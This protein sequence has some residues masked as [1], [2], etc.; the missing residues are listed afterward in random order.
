MQK[1]HSE[2][3]LRFSDI[4]INANS[5]IYIYI[6]LKDQRVKLSAVEIYGIF[7]DNKI[8]FQNTNVTFREI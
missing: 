2:N 6:L 8:N 4:I 3:L 1:M 5:Y 7:L